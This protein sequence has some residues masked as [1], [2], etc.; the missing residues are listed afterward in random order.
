VLRLLVAGLSNRAIAEEQIVSI[1]TIRTQVQSI[2][3]KLGVNNRVEAC[4]VARHLH[5]LDAP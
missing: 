1:N 3:R 5:L 4:E 2:Y